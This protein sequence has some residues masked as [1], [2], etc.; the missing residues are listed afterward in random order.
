MSELARSLSIIIDFHAREGLSGTRFAPPATAREFTAYREAFGEQVPAGLAEVYA[1]IGAGPILTE[2][3]LSIEQVIA[4]RRMWDGIIAASEDPDS[5]YHEV[6]TSLDP[7]AVSALYWKSGWVQFTADGGGNGFA[8]DLA[9]EPGGI[10]GQVISVGPDEDYRTVIA[11]SVASLFT[12]IAQLLST[13]RFSNGNEDTLLTAL[14]R[15][16]G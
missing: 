8:V 7:D 13:G 3:L 5:D 10:V 2:N 4:T 12:R 9:P 16:K 11:D 14:R 6:I 1:V 15:E